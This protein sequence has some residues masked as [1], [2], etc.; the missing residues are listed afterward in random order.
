[1]DMKSK[2]QM[3]AASFLMTASAFWLTSCSSDD[4]VQ[5]GTSKADLSLTLKINT[6][7]VGSRATAWT[8]D[9]AG[10]NN[11]DENKINT[12]TVGIFSSDG[13]TVKTIVELTA[14]DS[15][16]NTLSQ[17]GTEARIVTTSLKADDKVLVVANAPIGKGM[18]A[19]VSTVAGFQAVQE[20][21]KDA[22]TDRS[23]EATEIATNLPMYGEGSLT[24]S[25][26][27]FNASVQVQH[28]VAK[29]TLDDLSV[30]FD[31]NGAYK[32]A[33]FTP[34]EFFLVNVPEKLAFNN[35]AWVSSASHL[36]GCDVTTTYTGLANSVLN[37]PWGNYKEYLATGTLTATA[38]S[39]SNTDFNSKAY[40]YAT[41]NANDQTG[42]KNLKLII[43]GNFKVGGVDKGTVFYP[44][45]LNATYTSDGNSSAAN[46]G[47]TDKFKVYPNKNYKCKVVIKTIGTID[48]TQNL[49]PQAAS[50]T[51]S[52]K[53][54]EEA[55][56]TTTFE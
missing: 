52:V 34:T 46:N 32:D 42:D 56:Q 29:I 20:D 11:A 51:V 12:L 54:F 36:H 41:P 44:V 24:G 53:N 9:P 28:Q 49:D 8:S 47:G 50:I 17:D 43:A 33:E 10:S 45:N 39:R 6:G 23:S 25:G 18:F 7:N 55:N 16:G 5:G 3:L 4:V 48:P 27:Q 37:S 40:F 19:G 31:A 14:G 26:S 21:A 13:N 30:A 35:D 22:L 1:M 38:L 15:N 2:F